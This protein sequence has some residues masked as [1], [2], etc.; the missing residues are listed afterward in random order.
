[1]EDF[2]DL[3]IL[4]RSRKGRLSFKGEA[5]PPKVIELLRAMM[6]GQYRVAAQDRNALYVLRSL[7]LIPSTAQPVLL[8][9]PP[10]G[11]IELWLAVKV[12]R[13]ASFAEALQ[14]LILEPST[15][16]ADL[17]AVV[18]KYSLK[19]LSTSSKVRYGNALATWIQWVLTTIGPG[20]FHSQVK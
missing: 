7:R 6:S 19:T 16:V 4:G 2:D 13:Q 10:K 8:E 12:S 14:L 17:G 11:Q 5:L 3:R 20:E 1:L 9:S 18:E 15:K